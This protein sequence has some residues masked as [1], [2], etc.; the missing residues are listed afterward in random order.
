ML[1]ITWLVVQ[2]H[3]LEKY[4]FVNGKDDIPYMKWTIEFMFETTNQLLWH[5]V[6]MS[7]RELDADKS[8]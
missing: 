6:A 2:F 7:S 1:I 8:E 3:N 5:I 4:E